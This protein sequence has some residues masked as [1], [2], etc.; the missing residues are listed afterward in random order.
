MPHLLQYEKHI[1]A[2]FCAKYMLAIPKR[3]MKAI[4][5]AQKPNSK[6]ANKQ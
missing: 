4:T 5:T 2:L 3:N 6:H 1:W